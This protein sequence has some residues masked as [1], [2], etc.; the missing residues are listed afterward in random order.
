MSLFL[1]EVVTYGLNGYSPLVK[2]FGM[3]VLSLL[4]GESGRLFNPAQTLSSQR[5]IL[6]LNFK[7]EPKKRRSAIAAII[8]ELQGLRDE[9]RAAHSQMQKA[10]YGY[11]GVISG[12]EGV[13]AIL[14]KRAYYLNRL[15]QMAT[16]IKV[17]EKFTPSE[18]AEAKQALR[19]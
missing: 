6:V 9:V 7:L 8:E 2:V 19:N 18:A 1:P 5:I 16:G 11:A 13:I 10:R 14:P 15:F 17:V 12:L 3:A 4:A